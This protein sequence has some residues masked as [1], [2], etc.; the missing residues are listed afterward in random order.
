MLCRIES[1]QLP[2]AGDLVAG[3]LLTGIARAAITRAMGLDAREFN[4]PDWL[5][6]PA[7]CFVTLTLDGRLRG[8]IGSLNAYRPLRVD[9]EANARAAA[10]QDPRFPPV[11]EQELSPLRIEVSLLSAGQAMNVRDEDDA[12]AQLRPQVDGIILTYGQHRATF[13]PQVWEQLPDPGLFLGQLKQKAGLPADFWAPG[14]ELARYTVDTF[15]EDGH[16]RP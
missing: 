16:A 11:T 4:H 14:I 2:S 9:L 1:P 13:L 6:I 10:F 5:E 3:R 8:C 7:A 15:T 12:L